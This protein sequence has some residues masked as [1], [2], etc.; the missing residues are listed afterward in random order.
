M[1]ILLFLSFIF[2]FP[3]F[4]IFKK[5]EVP[6]PG[7]VKVRENFYADI[8]EV[9]NA[10]YLEFLFWMKRKHGYSSTEYKG[11]LPDTNL[12]IIF[13]PHQYLYLRDKTY[14][15]YPVIGVSF[16]QAEAFCKWRTDMVNA[17]IYAR[18]K[19][20]TFLA[21]DTL[22]MKLVAKIY[23]YRL[24]TKA[25]WEEIA[26]F[27]YDKKTKAKIEKEQKTNGNFLDPTRT[28]RNDVKT[29]TSLPASYYPNSIGVYDIFGNL[30]EYIS[31]KGIA[32][33]GS[34]QTDQKEC[35][36]Q[37]DFTYDKPGNQLGFRCVCVKLIQT[38]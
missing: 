37:K 8:T 28:K 30:S 22:D 36:V 34:W 27:D 9:K 4:D 6:P 12:W 18:E 1:K 38:K 23:E 13:K 3:Q 25:E 21:L 29:Y 19:K 20:L 17:N 7:T 32:K 10:D 15:Q 35:T 16:E 11:A 5:K 14:R 26:A 2:L 33:G 24:P 31:E